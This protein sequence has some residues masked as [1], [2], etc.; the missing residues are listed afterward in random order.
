MIGG[1]LALLA[2]LILVGL[3]GT[4]YHRDRTSITLSHLCMVC[5]GVLIAG[6]AAA[7]CVMTAGAIK[8]RMEPN[9]MIVGI[10]LLLALVFF[11]YFL[12]SALYIYMYRPFHYAFLI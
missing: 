6:L 3:V 12:A 9:H 7:G 10:A 11:C 8:K 2:C 5:I 1:A 4:I